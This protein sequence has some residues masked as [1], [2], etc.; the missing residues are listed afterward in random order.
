[1]SI[2]TRRLLV[3]ATLVAMLAAT[4]LRTRQDDAAIG[5][6]TVQRREAQTMATLLSKAPTGRFF[7]GFGAADLAA[8]VPRGRPVEPTAP[9]QLK[10]LLLGLDGAQKLAIATLDSVAIGDRTYAVV[11]AFVGEAA[12]LPANRVLVLASHAHAGT[13][14]PQPPIVNLA[15]GAREV[16]EADLALCAR[17]AARA[18]RKAFGSARIGFAQT[19]FPRYVAQRT[20]GATGGVDTQ[21]RTALIDRDGARLL[22]WSYAAHPTLA[23]R[24]ASHRDADYPGRVE[25]F[26]KRGLHAQMAIFLPGQ[27]AQAGA[28]ATRNP[29]EFASALAEALA[30]L[31]V[32]ADGSPTEQ[33]ALEMTAMTT[34]EGVALPLF[35]PFTLAPYIGKQLGPIDQRIV[36]INLC[37]QRIVALA[38]EP[39]RGL[40]GARKTGEWLVGMAG[41]GYGYLVP[42]DDR[43]RGVEAPFVVLSNG[44]LARMRER[45]T[46]LFAQ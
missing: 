7:A 35:G 13:R 32:L 20:P 33:C 23:G 15:F 42:A 14:L 5:L 21:L 37:G 10:V 36:A 44:G 8:Q 25:G 26:L 30:G 29:Q 9:P 46:A 31:R 17:T 34:D 27:T 45:V 24:T 16:D 6:T 2:V 43:Y 19:D 22:L 39:A 4:G 18:A 41:T 28:A 38:G 40:F 12:G 3:C 1:M 11:A